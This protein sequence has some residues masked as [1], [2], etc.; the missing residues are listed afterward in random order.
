MVTLPVK[1]GTRFPAGSS[2]VTWT[3]GLI[4]APAT[5]V[6][7]CTVNASCVAMPGV[8]SNALLVMVVKPLALA[9]RVRSEERRVGKEWRCGRTPLDENTDVVV[10]S[11]AL[12]GVMAR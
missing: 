8:M 11:I 3:A 2:A 6:E 7:G 5:V 1:P 10:P 12:R 9:V 4:V